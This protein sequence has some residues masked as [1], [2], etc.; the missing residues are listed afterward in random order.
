MS[1][2]VVKDLE[3]PASTSNKIYIASGS[4]LDIAGSPDGASAI[5]LAVNG[6][7]ITSG[8]ITAARLPSMDITTSTGDVTITGALPST[9]TFAGA[10]APTVYYKDQSTTESSY[11]G[12]TTWVATGHGFYHAF[13]SGKTYIVA[14]DLNTYNLA[15]GYEGNCWGI[16]QLYTDTGSTTIPASGTTTLPGTSQTITLDGNLGMN[17]QGATNGSYAVGNY[18]MHTTLPFA[19]TGTTD[20]MYLTVRTY[21]TNV[22][23][24][25]KGVKWYVYEYDTAPATTTG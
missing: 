18:A 11:A 5:N 2:L 19:G 13:T 15:N 3:G 22:T 14:F 4:Q 20:V 9:I 8:T 7:D 24:I 10:K 17:G 1:K 16:Q 12:G 23:G 25:T 6:S 21:N